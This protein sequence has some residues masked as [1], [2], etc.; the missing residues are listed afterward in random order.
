M[1]KWIILSISIAMLLIYSCKEDDNLN[2][3]TTK[4]M[5]NTFISFTM[6]GKQYQTQGEVPVGSNADLYRWFVIQAPNRFDPNSSIGFG[7]R[8]TKI[9]SVQLPYTFKAIIGGSKPNAEIFYLTKENGE[10]IAYTIT[11]AG[12]KN[13]IVLSE[14]DTVNKLLKGHFNGMGAKHKHEIRNDSLIIT[15]IA[16]VTIT[17]GKYVLSYKK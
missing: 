11:S 8:N 5:G 2:A 14:V 9:D 10:D 13:T 17:D 3:D 7:M 1:K 16:D 15:F 6:D 4:P 12:F